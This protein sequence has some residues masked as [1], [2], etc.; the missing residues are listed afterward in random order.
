MCRKGLPRSRLPRMHDGPQAWA[1]GAV[2]VDEAG[3]GSTT[4][5]RPPRS[6]SA[7]AAGRQFDK[8]RG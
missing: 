7:G 6:A 1:L 5:A 4:G 3:G 2:G 8:A